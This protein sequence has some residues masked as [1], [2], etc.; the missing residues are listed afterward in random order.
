MTLEKLSGIVQANA[1]L[2]ACMAHAIPK[3]ALH[4]VRTEFSAQA[5]SALTH[6]LN[7]SVSDEA[8][9]AMRDQLDQLKKMLD[10]A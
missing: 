10:A 7:A 6:F 1:V 4:Q 9:A 8:I 2:M 5:E 3:V